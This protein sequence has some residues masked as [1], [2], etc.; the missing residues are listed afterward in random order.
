MKRR[1]VLRFIAAANTL[2]LASLAAPMPKPTADRIASASMTEVQQWLASGDLST[3]DLLHL[4]L[5]RIEAIDRHGPTLRAVIELNPEAAALAHEADARKRR[6]EPPRPM[7]G[8]FVLVK[9]NVATVGPMLTSAGSLALASAPAQADAF[10]VQKLH[11]SGALLLGKTNLSEW[12]NIRSSRSSSGW[13]ARGGLTRNPH[14]L[15]RSASGSSSGSAV[16]VAAGLV[17][18][19]IGTET[20]GSI[21]SP[22]SVNG[23]VGIKPTIGLVSRSGIV[24]ISSTQDT[25]GPMARTVTDAAH[26]LAAIAG[27]DA[28]DPATRDAP[29]LDLLAHLKI[30]A[31][32]G[33]R[34]GIVRSAFGK[35]PEALALM[36]RAMEVLKG[37]GAVLIDNVALPSSDDY[38]DAELL[39][40]LTELKVDLAAYLARYAATGQPRSLADVMA[41]N[42]LHANQELGEFGQE[43]FEQAEATKGLNDVAYLEA[44]A[45]CRRLARSEGIEKALS[46]NALDALIAPTND[47]SWTID[48]VNGDH[49]GMG[50]SSPAAV[51]GLPHVTVPMGAV[52]K[53]PV[54]LSFVGA[55]FSEPLLIGMA[56]AYEQASHARV[57][58]T[59]QASV[60]LLG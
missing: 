23:I 29:T 10:I 50:F 40:L 58:P 26:L 33:K 9:D 28:D 18:C 31:L 13:S 4:H 54:G 7:E 47:P 30:D 6:K 43:L 32:R 34:L 53:L 41:F 17:T 20:D 1:T 38:G 12:A 51:A 21:V 56:Y 42:L 60:T 35:Q 55:A 39:V 27:R 11:Q 59:F 15:D 52:R 36:D 22:S 57:S 5:A 44:L 16:A 25:A 19:A 49:P 45:K 2:P 3:S 14:I 8:V 37:Q 46:E 24:P 48:L